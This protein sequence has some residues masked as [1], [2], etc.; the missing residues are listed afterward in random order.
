MPEMIYIVS[1]IFCLSEDLPV[2]YYAKLIFSLTKNLVKLWC[3][4][5]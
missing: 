3:I 2:K 5:I 4:S 1:G